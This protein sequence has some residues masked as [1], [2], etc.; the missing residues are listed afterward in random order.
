MIEQQE[1]ADYINENISMMLTMEEIQTIRSKITPELA[2]VLMKLLGDVSILV[3][4][5]DEN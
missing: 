2:S 4:I 1:V 3:E 5:R